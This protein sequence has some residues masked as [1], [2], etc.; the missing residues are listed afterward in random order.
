MINW[1]RD[2]V[3]LRSAGMNQVAYL[4]RDKAEKKSYRD[5]NNTRKVRQEETV[6]F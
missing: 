2:V 5:V 1:N 4:L 3:E 6:K